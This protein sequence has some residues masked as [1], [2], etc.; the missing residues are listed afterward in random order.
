MGTACFKW[1]SLGNK[2]VSD[3][4]SRHHA[5]NMFKL[6]EVYGKKVQQFPVRVNKIFYTQ[7]NNEKK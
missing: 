2:Y 4:A 3:Q 5:L 6:P 1:N 7:V